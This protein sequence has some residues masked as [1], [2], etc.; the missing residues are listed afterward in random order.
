MGGEKNTGRGK[1]FRRLRNTFRRLNLRRALQNSAGRRVRV[2]WGA[3]YQPGVVPGQSAARSLFFGATAACAYRVFP[4][5]AAG[6]SR[7]SAPTR[8]RPSSTAGTPT[9]PLVGFVL[10]EVHRGD[11]AARFAEALGAVAE[12][13]VAER[14]QQERGCVGV[15]GGG[16]VALLAEGVE[17]FED[18]L[19]SLSLL[20]W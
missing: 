16:K 17:V 5:V 13:N 19:N 14:A 9:S 2:V 20:F 6:F 4:I 18:E 15:F 11:L 10:D 7:R 12:R 3:G 8:G 1:T